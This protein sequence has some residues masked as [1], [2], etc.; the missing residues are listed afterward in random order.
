MK[1]GFSQQILEKKPELENIMEI[2]PVGEWL[3]RAD[4]RTDGRTD[5][6]TERHT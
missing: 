2:R 4:G 5:I 1:L 6:R 3:L